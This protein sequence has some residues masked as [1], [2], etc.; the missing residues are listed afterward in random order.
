MLE[1]IASLDRELREAAQPLD[2]VYAKEV[3]RS[4]M[5]TRLRRGLMGR[6]SGRDSGCAT[7]RALRKLRQAAHSAPEDTRRPL[8]EILS[9]LE[10]KDA[11][12]ERARRHIRYRSLLEL[13]LYF[14]VPLSFALLAALIAH[15][16]SVFFYW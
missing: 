1:E 13:W 5:K 6:I 16:V 8:S 2:Q 7:A 3:E 10:R 12:L 14:H 4:V 9:I 15:I 11:L